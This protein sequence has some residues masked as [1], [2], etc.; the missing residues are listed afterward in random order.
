MSVQKQSVL[1]GW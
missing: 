1:S